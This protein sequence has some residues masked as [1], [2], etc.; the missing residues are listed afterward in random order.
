MKK[1]VVSE[2][3]SI[4]RTCATTAR[5]RAASAGRGIG[6]TR[7]EAFAS[8]ATIVSIT[9]AAKAITI[10]SVISPVIPSVVTIPVIVAISSISIAVAVATAIVSPIVVRATATT[11]T[12]AATPGATAFGDSLGH[13]HLDGGTVYARAIDATNR[14]FGIAIVLE[15]NKTESGGI[16]CHPHVTDISKTTKG[17]LEVSLRR[18][19]PQVADVDLGVWFADVV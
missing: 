8:A 9:A 5:T 10:K 14:I 2:N 16:S 13:L 11:T 3:D 12:T 18:A 4:E 7:A 15:V 17:L 6:R 19:R 1:L